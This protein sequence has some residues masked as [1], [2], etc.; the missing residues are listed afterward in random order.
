MASCHHKWSCM[1]VEKSGSQN[2]THT[3]SVG[4][5][6]WSCDQQPTRFVSATFIISSEIDIY[7]NLRCAFWIMLCRTRLAHC[8][9]PITEHP[10]INL[11]E[12]NVSIR[13]GKNNVCLLEM[14]TFLLRPLE[15]IPDRPNNAG[16]SMPEEIGNHIVFRLL[17]ARTEE[18]G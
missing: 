4:D 9:N 10:S 1:W 13:I 3:K 5:R 14:W 2:F 7:L 17:L 11:I 8:C 16:Q 18:C 15:V 6:R 12:N